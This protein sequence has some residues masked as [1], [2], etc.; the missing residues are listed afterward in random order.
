MSI[1]TVD[2]NLREESESFLV[3][4]SETYAD[5]YQAGGHGFT[6]TILSSD[7]PAEDYERSPAATGVT[8]SSETLAVTEGGSGTFTVA[9]SA[10]PGASTT[11]TLVRTQYFSP[12]D[13]ASG[14]VWDL[15]AAAV[16]P[17]TLTFTSGS[18]GNWGT[19]QTVT[20]T[21]PEDAD[22]CHERL[23][24]LVLKSSAQ[25]YAYVYV[26]PN[27]GSYNLH[28]NGNYVWAGSGRGEY[29]YQLVDAYEPAGGTSSSVAGVT[30][31]V[32]DNDGGA[33]GGV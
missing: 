6:V 27:N 8:L 33:C 28:A 15:N 23:V 9:L 22:S 10:D 18:S 12:D 29:N 19:A 16:S 25:V 21:A 26:G 5:W 1:P 3:T 7:I 17:E 32:N 13:G 14:Q 24:V 11:V 4:L 20:V 2:D 30:V 31:T